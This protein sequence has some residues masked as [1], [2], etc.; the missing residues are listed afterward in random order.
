[1]SS[2]DSVM[3]SRRTTSAMKPLYPVLYS[4]IGFIAGG[5][6][7]SLTRPMGEIIYFLL[8]F[9]VCCFAV[10]VLAYYDFKRKDPD[11]LQTEEY[12]LR[13]ESLDIIRVKGSQIPIVPTSIETLADP[14]P[15]SI[16]KEAAPTALTPET[17]KDFQNFIQEAI[18]VL[19]ENIIR[20]P[21]R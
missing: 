16:Q 19:S 5:I 15:V 7:L 6:G 4:G 1:M 12:R 10:Y 3:E 2:L 14:S 17:A 11:R 18:E 8:A 9:G 21:R 20:S 13:R